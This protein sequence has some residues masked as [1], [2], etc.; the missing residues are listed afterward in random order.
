MDLEDFLFQKYWDIVEKDACNFVSKFFKIGWILPN[1]NSNIFIL[2]PKSKDAHSMKN[3]RPIDLANFKFKNISKIIDNILAP[4][5]L[6]MISN[7]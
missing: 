7:E 3:F 4:I 6:F 1:Y 5:M 2:I